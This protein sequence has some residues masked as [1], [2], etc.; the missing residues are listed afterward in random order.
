MRSRDGTNFKPDV[1]VDRGAELVVCDIQVSWEGDP[2][3]ETVYNNK[4]NVY[5]NVKFRKAA[6]TK[7][8][9]KQLIFTP[10]ILGARGT[11]PAVNRHALDILRIPQGLRNSL[12]HTTLKGGASIHL[13]FMR[14][15]WMR[16]RR[17]GADDRARRRCACAVMRRGVICIFSNMMRFMRMIGSGAISTVQCMCDLV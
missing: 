10:L 15:V 12:V 3:W 17:N 7:W 5:D 1:V 16:R 2:S 11:L 8:P 14:T 4:K 13:E 9:D 6:T